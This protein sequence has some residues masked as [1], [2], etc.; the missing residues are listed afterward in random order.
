MNRKL[1]I[2]LHN[3]VGN[4]THINSIYDI[5]R[6]QLLRLNDLLR[7]NIDKEYDTYDLY[8]D[9]GYKSFKD[10]V[11]FLD[12]GISHNHIRCAVI[13]DQV[14]DKNKLT[15]SEIQ[16]LSAEGY[17]IDSHG[18]SHAALAVF[19]DKKL[20]PTSTGGEYT[21]SAY[22]QDEQLSENQVL[23][24]AIESKISLEKLLHTPIN[25]FVLPYGL[26]NEQTIQIITS[27]TNYRKI[28][29]CHPGI[30]T[31][32][33]LAP[34]LLITQENINDV[35]SILKTLSDRYR[36]LTDV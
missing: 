35:E 1:N 18:T 9:D 20:L 24:Q 29:T 12:L 3:V 26:Y 17:G 15:E 10:I 32:Q 11:C 14:G 16:D 27:K 36:L 31:G 6:D 8:F 28:L 30:D 2:C 22:G 23:F 5:T 19:K 34:R 21:N 33:V 7:Q 13:S 25:N 4:D